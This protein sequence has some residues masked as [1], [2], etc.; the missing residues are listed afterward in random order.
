M[1]LIR[2]RGKRSNLIYNLTFTIEHYTLTTAEFREKVFNRTCRKFGVNRKIEKF[3]PDKVFDIFVF[4]ISIEVIE[5][6]VDID[7]SL[8]TDKKVIFG[9][10]VSEI[11]SFIREVSQ[12]DT[13][14]GQVLVFKVTRN[15]GNGSH[16][17]KITTVFVMRYHKTKRRG[18][19]IMS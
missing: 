3:K 16:S 17:R 18:K 1:F 11:K 19:K 13:Y 15:I 12:S 10:I 9:L 8:M 7:E 5:A 14:Q 6:D 2:G 4:L